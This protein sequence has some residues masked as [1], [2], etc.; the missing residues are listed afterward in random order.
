MRQRI[1]FFAG[2]VL[3]ILVTAGLLYHLYG[4]LSNNAAV[5]MWK[6][7]SHIQ[8]GFQ[9]DSHHIPFNRT[10]SE[11]KRIAVVMAIHQDTPLYRASIENHR[12]Y[13]QMHGYRFMTQSTNLLPEAPFPQL[14]GNEYQ[15]MA[16]LM[17]AVIIGLDSNKYDWILC[18]LFFRSLISY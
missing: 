14:K 17:Q 10:S 16:V 12:R 9:M 15:K 7:S 3:L 18:A 6:L 5:S 1:T 4:F 13:C 2:I 8:Y 11:S